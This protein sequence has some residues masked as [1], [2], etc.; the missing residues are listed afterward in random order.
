[1]KKFFILTCKQKINF[2]LPVFVEILQIYCKPVILGTLILSP[3]RKLSSLCAGTKRTSSHIFF[4][5]YCKDM[6]TSYFGNLGH[7]LL[8]TPKMIKLTCRI[9]LCMPKTNFMIHF[10]LEIFY[11]KESC[12]LIGQQHFGPWLDNQDFGR[13]VI[14]GEMSVTIIVFILDYF[15]EKLMTK[16]SKNSNYLFGKNEF[17]RKKRALSLLKSPI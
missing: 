14:S 13:Y 5:R 17:S 4:W 1:M 15:Q 6:E 3:G 10:I 12:S 11:F 16:I 8:R 7:A 9:F 2:I